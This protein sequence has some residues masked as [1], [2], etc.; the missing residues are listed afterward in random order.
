MK[1]AE[2]GERGSDCGRVFALHGLETPSGL[3]LPQCA[4]FSNSGH[5]SRLGLSTGLLHPREMGLL[6]GLLHSRD[7]KQW[8]GLCYACSVT[9]NQK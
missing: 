4:L 7:L 5:P 6:R 2:L 8:S 3:P 1:T 9:V